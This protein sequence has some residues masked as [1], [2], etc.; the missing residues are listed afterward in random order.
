MRNFNTSSPSKTES[1]TT[2]IKNK[3]AHTLFGMLLSTCLLPGIA[4]SA[5][6]ATPTWPSEMNFG[7][8]I[9]GDTPQFTT[10]VIA[11]PPSVNVNNFH[12]GYYMLVGPKDSYAS[13]DVIRGNDDFLGVKKVYTWRELV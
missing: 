13:F 4:Q 5:P 10:S 6:P 11:A 2:K 12:P 7:M 1:S 3:L 9:V 8:Q